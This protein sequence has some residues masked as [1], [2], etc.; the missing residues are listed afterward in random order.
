MASPLLIDPAVNIEEEKMPA[1][2]K[3][4]FYPVKLGEKER[5]V[6]GLLQMKKSKP[7]MGGLRVLSEDSQAF[8]AAMPHTIR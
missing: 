8:L 7:S 2:E 4:L 5:Q 3:G 1:Y 6:H